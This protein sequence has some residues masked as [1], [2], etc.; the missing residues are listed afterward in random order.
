M[1]WI[2]LITDQ[3]WIWASENLLVISSIKLWEAFSD[4]HKNLESES[5]LKVESEFLSRITE[6]LSKID[7]DFNKLIFLWEIAC[8]TVD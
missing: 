4:R 6:S 8:L 7:R 1:F 5:L 2:K 3:D